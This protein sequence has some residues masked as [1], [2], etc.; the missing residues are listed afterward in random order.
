MTVFEWGSGASTIFFAR[1]VARV[2]SI[3]YD[4]GWREAVAQRL[5][6]HGLAN[7]ELRHLPPEPGDDGAP[8][9]SSDPSFSGMSFR[10]YVHSVLDYADEAFDV[11]LVDG[12]A[13]FGC[14]V[15]ALPKL[16]EDGVLILD[17]SDRED[18]TEAC[19]LLTAGGWTARHF[20]GPGPHSYWPV[21][22]R[23]TAFFRVPPQPLP[24]GGGIPAEVAAP[25]EPS[26]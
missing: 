25:T 23:T 14:L 7:A 11:I 8:Y 17:D 6:A 1:R 16:K 12:R 15:T 26:S 22:S 19:V 18:A 13:R 21:F 10:R 4:A 9:R 3:E 2:V 5:R 20:D 24:R